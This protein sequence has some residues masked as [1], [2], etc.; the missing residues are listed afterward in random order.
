MGDA[1]YSQP[2]SSRSVRPLDP[3]VDPSVQDLRLKSRT[4]AVVG[5]LTIISVGATLRP[6]PARSRT[7][8]A[9]HAELASHATNLSAAVEQYHRTD[10]ELGGRLQKIANER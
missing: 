7:A 2:A 10:E 8:A 3:T 5:G 9:A 6:D 1:I 4:L